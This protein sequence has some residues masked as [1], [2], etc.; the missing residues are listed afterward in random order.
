MECVYRFFY[1]RIGDLSCRFLNDIYFFIIGFCPT[2]LMLSTL[3][4][5]KSKELPSCFPVSVL[6]T[7]NPIAR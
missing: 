3:N 5:E 2:N 1:Q 7:T 6:K 4:E